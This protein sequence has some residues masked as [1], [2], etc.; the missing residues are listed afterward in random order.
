[1]IYN[2]KYIELGKKLFS[3]E[4]ANMRTIELFPMSVFEIILLVALLDNACNERKNN[5]LIPEVVNFKNKL[6]DLLNKVYFLKS[7][8][9]NKRF[10]NQN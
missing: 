9:N 7:E 1:M 4:E 6:E 3:V 2:S 5:P 8:F 10:P